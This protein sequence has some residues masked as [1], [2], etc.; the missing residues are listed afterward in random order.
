MYSPCW[1]R[2]SPIHWGNEAGYCYEL[3][4]KQKVR[5]FQLSPHVAKNNSS[6]VASETQTHNESRGIEKPNKSFARITSKK[7]SDTLNKFRRGD[8]LNKFRR[9][10]ETDG[11]YQSSG[12]KE[13]EQVYFPVARPNV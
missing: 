9:G 8:T 5:Y 3:D 7:K 11:I 1:I 12:H 6:Q 2:H 10:A 4:T 13:Q